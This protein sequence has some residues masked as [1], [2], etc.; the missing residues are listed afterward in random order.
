MHW[1]CYL[2]DFL[3]KYCSMEPNKT[4]DLWIWWFSTVFFFPTKH[5]QYLGALQRWEKFQRRNMGETKVG[6]R[7]LV[8]QILS[9]SKGCKPTKAGSRK[10]HRWVLYAPSY[11]SGNEINFHTLKITFTYKVIISWLHLLGV[12]KV[13]TSLCEINTFTVIIIWLP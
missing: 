8:I 6:G 10:I 12:V 4:M 9:F 11:L 3:T 1:T 5:L 13:N 2:E 7:Y